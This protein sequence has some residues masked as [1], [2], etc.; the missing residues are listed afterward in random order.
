M[1][2]GTSASSGKSAMREWIGKKLPAG[3]TILDVG[4][5]GGTYSKLLADYG[6]IMDAVEA[7]EPTVE[8]IIDLY[9]SVYNV[10]VLD[11]DWDNNDY[12][13]IIMGDVLEHIAAEDA[14]LLI[15]VAL[16]HCKWLLVAVP[17]MY[18]QDA[19]E[20]NQYEIHKQPDLDFLVMKQRY[21]DLNLLLYCESDND[22]YND[23]G[24]PYHLRYAYYYAKGALNAQ[25]AYL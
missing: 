8:H 4:A 13:M 22:V 10:D 16:Q 5:G 1:W 24:T 12:D 18:E 25:F 14:E 9:R 17:F 11:F 23:D 19:I 15:H 6:Y 3:S 2:L 20:G 7:Y 21:P